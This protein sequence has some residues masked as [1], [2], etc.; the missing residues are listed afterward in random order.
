VISGPG[1]AAYADLEYAPAYP[2]GTAPYGMWKAARV[3]L[4]PR[5]TRG[6]DPDLDVAFI[7]LAPRDGERVTDVVGAT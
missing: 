4:D 5:W 2:N 1:R 6:A 3:T 7:E